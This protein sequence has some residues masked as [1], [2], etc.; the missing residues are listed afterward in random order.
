MTRQELAQKVKAKYPELQGSDDETVVA[1]VLDQYPEYSAYL[2][3]EDIGT[4]YVIESAKQFG[5]GAVETI[6]QAAEGAVINLSLGMADKAMSEEEFYNSPESLKNVSYDRYVRLNDIKLEKQKKGMEFADSIKS[7]TEEKLPEYINANEEY[8]NAFAG[9]VFR[10][11]GQFLGYGAVGAAG[12]AVGSPVGGVAAVYGTAF[13]N[14]QIEFLEDAERTLGLDLLEMDK[15]TRDKVVGGSWAYGLTTG[16]LDATVFKYITRVPGANTPTVKN[17]LNNL[18]KGQGVPSGQLKTVLANTA[19]AAVAE[20]TQESLGDGLTLDAMAKSLYD[21]DRELITGDAL[22]RRVTEFALGG[23]VGGLGKTGI[24]LI[25]AR[26]RTDEEVQEFKDTLKKVDESLKQVES[27]DEGL[28]TFKVQFE[29]QA[30]GETDIT[31]VKANTEEEALDYF[32]NTYK[33]M[34]V[35]DS[36]RI[37]TGE[38]QTQETAPVEEKPETLTQE[39]LK[40]SARYLKPTSVRTYQAVRDWKK[41]PN[42]ADSSQTKKA[43]SELKRPDNKDVV[44]MSQ[45]LLSLYDV[46]DGRVRVYRGASEDSDPRVLSGWSLNPDIASDFQEQARDFGEGEI[47]VATIP[48]KD[49]LYKDNTVFDDDA[50]FQEQ[51]LIFDTVKNL[52]IEKQTTDNIKDSFSPKT[53]QEE[54]IVKSYRMMPAQMVFEEEGMY[55]PKIT[56]ADVYP[57]DLRQSAR[58]FKDQAQQA[59][60]KQSDIAHEKTQRSNTIKTYGLINES[61]YMPEEGRVLDFGAGLGEGA[62]LMGAESF[63]PNPQGGFQPTYT[64]P[65]QIPSNSYDFVT[66]L[67]VLN[68]IPGQQVRNEVV[69][70][71]GRVLKKNGKAVITAR[72]DVDS[73]YKNKP[74]LKTESFGEVGYISGD[75]TYQKN[76]KQKELVDYIQGVLGEGFKVT[77]LDVSVSGSS[78]LIEKVAEGTYEALQEAVMATDEEEISLE[79]IENQEEA[80][81]GVTLDSLV[82]ADQITEPTNLRLS[83]RKPKGVPTIKLKDFKGQRIFFLFADQT[84]VG[85]YKGLDGNLNIS[86][87]GGPDYPN[88]KVNKDNDIGWAVDAKGIWT[89]LNN[90]VNLSSKGVGF[91]TLFP[92]DNLRGNKTFLKAYVA[93]V[94]N[95]IKKG[96]LTEKRFLEVANELRNSL[97]NSSANEGPSIALGGEFTSLDN[98]QKRL[99]DSRFDV[100]GQSFFKTSENVKGE[101]TGQKIGKIEYVNEGFPNI[102]DMIDLF[103]DPRFNGL[104]AGTVVSAVEF[105]KGQPKDGS[106]SA[107]E[108][109][110]P[111][112]S[113]YEYLIKGKGLGYFDKPFQ[114]YD[115]IKD[116]YRSAQPTRKYGEKT[117]IP[118]AL[119]PA[120]GEV[121]TFGV[122]KQGRKIL[123]ARQPKSPAQ[124]ELEIEAQATQNYITNKFGDI[125]NSPELNRPEKKVNGDV[126]QFEKKLKVYMDIDGYGPQDQNEVAYYDPVFHTIVVNLRNLNTKTFSKEGIS[127]VIREEIIHSIAHNKGLD[128]EALGKSLTKSQRYLIEQVYNYGEPMSDYEAGGE[129]FRA[130]VQN[131]SYGGISEQMTTMK[132]GKAWMR[133]KR[134]IQSIQGFVTRA[135][136]NTSDPQGVSLIVDVANLLAKID[137]QARPVDQKTVLAARKVISPVTGEPVINVENFTEDPI[138]TEKKPILKPLILPKKDGKMTFAEAYLVPAGQT[139]RNIHASLEKVFTD[140]VRGKDQRVHQLHRLAES[141]ANK[142]KGITDKGDKQL[143]TQLISFSKFDNEGSQFTD[144]QAQDLY[145]KRDALLDKYGMFNDYLAITQALKQIRHEVMTYVGEIGFV[146]NYWPRYLSP[147][148]YKE[149]REKYGLDEKTFQDS[150]KAENQ[151]RKENTV[152]AFRVFTYDAETNIPNPSN[153]YP[154][155]KEAQAEVDSIG[156]SFV[157]DEEIAK[158]LPA[159][160]KGSVEEALFIEKEL[161]G[162]GFDPKAGKPK[163]TKTRKLEIIPEEDLEFYDSPTKAL[164]RYFTS[165]VSLIET[166]KFIGRMQPD[167]RVVKGQTIYQYDPRSKM[168]QTVQNLVNSPEFADTV[169]QEKLYQTLPEITRMLM[170]K[171]GREFGLFSW[172]RQF[173]YGTLLIEFTSTL[174][175]LYDLPFTMYDNG[176]FETLKSAANVATGKGIADV[177]ELFD[178]N[179]IMDAYE[180]DSDFFS[181]IIKTGLKITGFTKMDQFMKETTMDANY[182]RYSKISNDINPD[183]TIKKNV[184]GKRLVEA[185]KALKELNIFLASTD[186]QVQQQDIQKFLQAVKKNPNQRSQFENDLIKNVLIVKLFENQPMNILRLPPK[187]SENPNL[188][189]LIT[190]KSFMLVQINSTRNIALNDLFGNGRTKR[191]RADAALRLT[192][193]IGFFIAIGIPVDALKDWLTGR[194]G[195]LPDYAFNGAVR[196]FGINK[197]LFFQLRKE[198]LGQAML[199]FTLPVPLARGIGVLNEMS[200]VAQGEGIIESGIAKNLPLKDVL[201]YRI[202][203]VR[204]K[205]RKYVERRAKQEGEFLFGLPDPFEQLAPNPI[206]NDL[207]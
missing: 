26:P 117:N 121:R 145:S 198:G 95:A 123:G 116:L 161:S 108:A 194:P 174:S 128:S 14:R 125:F 101:M 136:K 99:G 71:I 111:E 87:Q 75:K 32:N 55:D 112:H 172:F 207:R 63:E 3:D 139:L 162:R 193:L 164:S 181:D 48:I 92:K 86:L 176:F 178:I 33:G 79:Q 171:G 51:E 70:D 54:A 77:P 100:R 191:E 36:G 150:I 69:K 140:Y 173:S 39:E 22:G 195:Y 119:K 91:V 96:R 40:L 72:S 10:G 149:L 13:F 157:K 155:R 159:M 166:T 58:K 109:K 18:V 203:E 19:K 135:F 61:K 137:P 154:T 126:V 88:T 105:E 15:D 131:F 43:I 37:Y 66:S 190:M 192:K 160:E 104:E 132:Q 165:M 107:K 57:D 186:S 78:V 199:D 202:P 46:G 23:T 82:D 122:D 98:F 201:Y 196:V 20:G 60:V 62:A 11:L 24:D 177:R 94:R 25:R 103:A 206:I 35:P 106:I 6:G 184:R 47:T 179:R 188:R 185:K 110:V 115:Q 143:L 127:M 141:F 44:S 42:L 148:K 114:L 130:A 7:W 29:Q 17:L 89:S 50:V 84:R 64:D 146:E 31:E 1:G 118:S 65:S 16:A 120:E 8:G 182:K 147:K 144:E 158:P 74:E 189:G 5:L 9:Q 12:T 170:A 153:L 83:A 34:Y 168:A 187:I 76:F 81:Q 49:V 67:S 56:E 204:A 169:N 41:N 45:E 90:K 52:V 68:V 163:F 142:F 93:E 85:T 80:Q 21:D 197:F 183:G 134:L 27:T 180:N 129:Y 200:A 28:Q 167:T 38:V 138:K 4:N 124:V 205:Q 102:V 156:N 2:S 175:Q 151:K 59:Q 152:K 73:Y 53:E 133:V 113:A 97:I 30:S